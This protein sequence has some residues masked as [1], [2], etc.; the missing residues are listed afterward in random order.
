[1]KK[2]KPE[3]SN[4]EKRI[5][6]IYYSIFLFV[7]VFTFL[8]Y[9]FINA[10]HHL[11]A[12]Y[13]ALQQYAIGSIDTWIQF[14]GSL[15]GGS[16]TLIALIL[17][18]QYTD[19]QRNEEKTLNVM[20]ICIG[21]ILDQN[22][23]AD[24][25]RDICRFEIFNISNNL[26]KDFK[27]E[28]FVVET[29]MN[30]DGSHSTKSYIVDPKEFDKVSNILPGGKKIEIKPQIPTYEQIT[31][32]DHIEKAISKVVITYSDIFSLRQYTLHY[33]IEFGLRIKTNS[34]YQY[35][36]ADEKIHFV[37]EYN[38]IKETNTHK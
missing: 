29:F 8:A 38:F 6:R 25:L 22:K 34:P 9:V 32:D 2:Q 5:D 1:M 12:N 36:T 15:L 35:K 18:F 17:T 13:P 20:P 31:R 11:A 4:E 24:Q 37:K 14:L 3:K 7:L 19:K 30:I 27:I 16:L 10:I 23:T 33:S 28:S 26:V 21:S